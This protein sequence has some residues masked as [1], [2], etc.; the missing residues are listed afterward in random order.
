MPVQ[1]ARWRLRHVADCLSPARLG[2][3]STI[4]RRAGGSEAAPAAAVDASASNGGGR[5]QRVLAIQSHIVHGNLG[6]KCAVFPLQLLGFEV[7]TI[8][9]VQY[10]HMG[11]G[12]QGTILSGAELTALIDGLD[13]TRA[14]RSFTAQSL[15]RGHTEGCTV[16]LGNRA[17]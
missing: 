4:A 8:S 15:T 10:S 14:M 6:N 11:T 3:S 17:G 16:V 5:P 2:V 9:T 7:D 12:R 1:H 13:Q